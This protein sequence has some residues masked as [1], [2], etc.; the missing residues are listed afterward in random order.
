MQYIEW[1]CQH[2]RNPCMIPPGSADF[3][4]SLDQ[5]TSRRGSVDKYLDIQNSCRASCLE[6]E[7]SVL[8]YQS[9]CSA[10]LYLRPGPLRIASQIRSTISDE[11]R[12]I[13]SY[14]IVSNQIISYHIA[15]R[16][17]SARIWFNLDR[18]PPILPLTSLHFT[19]TSHGAYQRHIRGTWPQRKSH[20]CRTSNSQ[21]VRS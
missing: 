21:L 6:R 15:I 9:R 17:L 13:I 18:G 8:L 19:F 10:N 2:Q 20:K 14:R 4:G 16:W 3:A 1:V 12:I 5:D 7:H 11:S